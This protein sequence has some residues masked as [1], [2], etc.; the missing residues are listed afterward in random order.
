MMTSRLANT[1]GL[2]LLLALTSC[3]SSSEQ[4]SVPPAAPANPTAA[5]ASP[6]PGYD[7]V[8]ISDGGSVSGVITVSGPIPKLPKREIKKDQQ[9]CGTGARDSERLLVSSGGG[10]KNA[11]VIVEGVK[12]GKAVPA[13]L[14]NVQIDQKNC[15]YAPHVMAIAVNSD[16]A[17]RNTDPLLHNIH[18]YQND[19]SLFNIAQ[20]NQGQVNTHKLDKTGLVYAECDVHGWMQ[21]H[22]AVVDSPYFAI[23]DENGKFNIPEVPPGTYKVR[24]WHEFLG[25]KT[26][27]VN[28][29]PKSD[30]ALN[31]DLK[32]LLAAKNPGGETGKPITNAAPGGTGEDKATADKKTA[33]KEVVVKMK[34]EGNSFSYEP[35]EITIKV[36]TTVRWVNDSDNKHSATDDPEM[37]KRAGEAVLPKGTPPWTS[38][39]LSNGDSFT[40]T[41]TTPGKYKY[42]C[43]NHGQFGMEGTINVVP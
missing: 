5:D 4:P 22:V 6:I 25:D 20:P 8:Q 42:F 23:T 3:R 21:G 14:R 30:V 28:V 11:I 7:V 27:D 12:H 17:V 29:T 41:F 18:F 26:Q 10:L 19:E 24:I 33:D 31:L 36:G 43:R 38:P 13:S 16:I 1:L 37:E 39:F 35:A 9:L 2:A 32:D 40:R 34:S 15:E